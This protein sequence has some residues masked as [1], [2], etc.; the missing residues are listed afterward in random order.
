MRAIL[1]QGGRRHRAGSA[2]SAIEG[3]RGQPQAVRATRSLIS[4]QSTI[5]ARTPQERLEA[6]VEQFDEEQAAAILKQWMRGARSMS[7]SPSAGHSRFGRKAR[8]WA[9]RTPSKAG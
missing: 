8:P 2:S 5:D 9:C 1:D 3:G 7:V 4:L 6:A